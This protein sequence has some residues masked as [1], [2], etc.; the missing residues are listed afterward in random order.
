MSVS[1]IFCCEEVSWFQILGWNGRCRID[2]KVLQFK[3]WQ[4]NAWP[5]SVA[6]LVVHYFMHSTWILNS[7]RWNTHFC[8]A[9][10]KILWYDKKQKTK[11]NQH[12]IAMRPYK[13][14]ICGM[15]LR[16]TSWKSYL[17]VILQ[18]VEGN[19]LLVWNNLTLLLKLSCNISKF[20]TNSL[21]IEIGKN[22]ME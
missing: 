7:V 5:A 6:K 4:F 21:G 18:R 8:A 15:E 10:L 19:N 2:F 17:V 16:G 13:V 22:E 9:S 14:L 3:G 11:K 1:H 12:C 20:Y